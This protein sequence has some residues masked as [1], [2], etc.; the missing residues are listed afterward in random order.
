MYQT[1]VERVRSNIKFNPKNV[2]KMFKEYSSEQHSNQEQI[3][4][5][6]R[7]VAEYFKQNDTTFYELT[8]QEIE[9]PQEEEP[10]QQ[11]QQYQYR[12]M[13]RDRHEP[14]NDTYSPL[15]R[16]DTPKFNNNTSRKND[17]NDVPMEEVVPQNNERR[18]ST[19]L[20]S[21]TS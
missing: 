4:D 21:K 16:R 6:N 11:Q 7:L 18:V 14:T 1:W 8:E 5:Y 9:K 2:N 3:I 20:A 13:L 10:M 17:I 12:T 15:Y 19:R